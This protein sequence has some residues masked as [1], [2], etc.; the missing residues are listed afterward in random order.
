MQAR[1]F[2]ARFDTRSARVRAF[3]L[4]E[5]REYPQRKDL[6][7]SIVDAA[8][9]LSRA[10]VDSYRQVVTERGVLAA[11]SPGNRLML[12]T[13]GGVSL[14]QAL[15]SITPDLAIHVL[16]DHVIPYSAYQALRHGDDAAFI[17]IRTEALAVRERRFM[18]QFHVQEAD[19]LL[20]ETD[21]DT[22]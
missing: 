11:S 3:I 15:L 14:R 5:L 16:A 13:P 18:A 8:A 9:M 1:P 22:E 10:S 7:G 20:G 19:E 12:S 17:A 6:D 21:I 4:W 2:P